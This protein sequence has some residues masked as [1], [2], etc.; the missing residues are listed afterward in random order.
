MYLLCVHRFKLAPKF[1][2]WA[3]C[4]GFKVFAGFVNNCECILMCFLNL[5]DVTN[6]FPHWSQFSPWKLSCF[7]FIWSS[8]SLNVLNLFSQLFHFNCLESNF[9]K[10]FE[11]KLTQ[12]T[13]FQDFLCKSLSVSTSE[14]F[15]SIHV[16]HFV[17][18]TLG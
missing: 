12:L 1:F 9:F 14:S 15:S 7:S 2:K 4:V 6:F 13:V 11:L 3:N 10:L 17:Y 16:R 5:Q 8:N 18:S